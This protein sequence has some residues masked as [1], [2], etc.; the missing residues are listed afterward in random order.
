MILYLRRS[1]TPEAA[2]RIRGP[3]AEA[4]NGI[5]FN[6]HGQKVKLLEFV[7]SPPWHFKMYTWTYILSIRTIYLTY[8][9]T[10]YLAYILASYLTYVLA[11]YLAVYLTYILK[12]YLAF[13]LTFYLTFYLA[14][15]LAFFLASYPAFYLAFYLAVEVQQCPLG[16]GGPRLR[17]SG[18]HWAREVPGWGPAVPTRDSRGPQLR[19]S[20]SHWY[21]EMVVEVQR[22]PLGSGAG[23]WGP[24]VPTAIRSWRGG[25]EEKE[26]AAEEGAESY[27]K[28]YL[29]I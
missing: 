11:F 19:S 7:W 14:F 26:K 25:E 10:F 22:R 8:S 9:L 15:Y 13:Y 3:S 1:P 16:S 27:H 28:I 17:S 2:E 12:F 18:G 4:S 6:W 20:S 29:K 23:S 24:A 5:T 21:R